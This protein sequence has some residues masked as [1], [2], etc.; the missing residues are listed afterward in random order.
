MKPN[1]CKSCR[2][3]FTRY[4]SFQTKCV[5][6]A[7]K[8]AKNNT[9]AMRR[10]ARR[11]T[12]A[13]LTALMTRSDWLRRAQSAFNAWVRYRDR[14][15]PCV[16]CGTVE[17]VQWHAGHYR[18]VGACPAL[19]FEP[20]NA[21]KQCSQCND[22]KAGNIVEYRLNLIERIGPEALRFLE[23]PHEPKKW[24]IP[25]IQ[26]IAEHYRALTKKLVT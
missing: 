21:H 12:K 10:A 23:G 11:E 5:D 13:K 1:L 24:T 8:A 19:R 7:L 4:T 17:A 6:C 16:S 26:A 15:K 2:Q 3:P 25:Q 14:S 20:L 18:S 22:W 9:E